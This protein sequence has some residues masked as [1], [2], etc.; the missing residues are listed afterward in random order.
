MT[1]HSEAPHP[2]SSYIFDNA[3]PL[4]EWR[5]KGLSD[6]FDP[7]TQR[8]LSERG[9]GRGWRCLEVG[10][11]GGSVARWLAGRVGPSG[12]VLATDINP[13][14]PVGQMPRNLEVRRHDI[15]TNGLPDGRFDLV[16]AR[17]V[18]SHLPARDAALARMARALKPGG[19]LLV[20]DFDVLGMTPDP[21]AGPAEMQLKSHE[22]VLQVMQDRQLDLRC[23]RRVARKMRELGLA[24][25]GAEARA[26]LWQSGSPSACV[27][28][29]N[30]RQMRA[31]IL[32][33]GL[34]DEAEFAADLD[35]LEDP[36]FGYSS[37]VLWATW[38]RRD[39]DFRDW[40][41]EDR[42]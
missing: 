25:I 4:A 27:I 19:W 41:A 15:T 37:P 40:V 42:R 35:R 18:L 12:C 10:T 31:S 26:Y 32:A 1:L 30:L 28:W 5:H 24:E 34:V 14:L 3:E 11:G 6:V 9:V 17:L 13:R 7:G 16:Y 22:A 36:F 38:G 23:G 29:A 8:L 33:T 20:E 21:D 39:V 2:G